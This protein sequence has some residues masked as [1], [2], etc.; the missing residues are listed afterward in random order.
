MKVSVAAQTY[1]HSVSAAITFL[2][3]L[4]LKEFKD[5]KP[6]SDFILLMNHLFD[7]LNSK[8][9]FGKHTKKPIDLNNFFD[10]ESS[11][12]DGIEFLKSL[13]DTAGIPLIKGPR[14]A[15]IIGFYV[16]A[17]SILAISKNLLER[18]ES[19]FEYMLTYRFSQDTLSK[20]R[21]HF[22]WNKN[23]TALQFKYALRSLLLKNKIEAPKTANCV[24]LVEEETEVGPGKVDSSVS[25]LLL[26]SNIW[27]SDVLHY[28]AGYIVRKVMLSI[29]C[30]DCAEALYHN[31]DDSG[32]YGYQSNLSLLS[33]KRYGNLIVPSYSVFKVVS[34]VDKLARKELCK[35]T[36]FTNSVT[37][38]ITSSVLQK[39]RN[40]TFSSIQAHSMENHILDN[41]L[42]DDHIT[43]L[44]KLIVSNYLTLFFHQFGKVYTERIIKRNNPSRRNKP[45]KTILFYNE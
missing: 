38:A 9:K 28:I 20:I 33:C 30:S 34:C 23:P 2:R 44:I 32:D 45:T 43:V 7:M 4:K 16:S 15:F 24:Q 6:T 11:L 5:S 29:D 14:K 42:R 8:S 12:K 17:L 13:K 19:P 37:S 22:G 35:W 27:R 1:S 31:S 21:S 41:H 40:S 3:N 36:S 25:N 10:I 39:T 26:S 18:T